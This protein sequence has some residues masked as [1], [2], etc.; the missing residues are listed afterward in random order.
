MSRRTVLSAEPATRL[1]AI[2]T[3]TA[4]MAK[5][6]MLGAGDLAN[7]RE[8]RRPSNRLGF[9]VQLCA[10]RYP[11][12]ALEPSESP[13]AEMLAFVARQ[14]GHDPALFADYTHRAETRREHL[15]QLQEYLR[16]RSFGLSDWRAC[17]TV[18]AQAAWA[19]D[20]G[21]PIIRTM[22]AHLRANNV[23]LP[24]AA[25]LERIGL[26]ARARAQEDLR[27]SRSGLV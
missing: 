16:L 13:P 25:V 21:G 6:Y 23:L 2:P 5:H 18:G 20:R 14:I 9:A 15:I 10:L 24:T 4:E 19:T 8:R 11:C 7:I 27:G 17:L 26:A 12:R 22:L 1:F 3:D